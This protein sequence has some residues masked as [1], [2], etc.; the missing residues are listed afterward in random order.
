[1]KILRTILVG[2][3]VVG[4][5]AFLSSLSF[6]EEGCKQG[7]M[8]NHDAKV[9]LLQDSAAALQKSN[10]DLAKGLSDY[11]DK[12]AKEMQ[13]WKTKHETKMKLLQDAAAALEKSNPD[14]AKGLQGMCEKSEKEEVGEKVEPKSEQGESK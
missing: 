9:K 12:E 8:M 7:K 13:D 11:A 1:M 5:V 2:L 6:A 14:L 4:M 3:A 10:P